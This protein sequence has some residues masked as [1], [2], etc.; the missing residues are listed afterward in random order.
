M[1]VSHGGALGWLGS[2]LLSLVAY[3]WA[4]GGGSSLFLPE[5]WACFSLWL[6]CLL[7]CMWVWLVVG[8]L[9]C[10]ACCRLLLLGAGGGGGGKA[11]VIR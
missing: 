8:G 2:L 4:V 7:A 6:G 1:C 9:L 5:L 3:A 11:F 10:R